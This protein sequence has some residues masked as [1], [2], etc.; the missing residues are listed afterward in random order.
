MPTVSG[1]GATSGQATAAA[2]SSLSRD[3]VA[4][5]TGLPGVAFQEGGVYFDSA[6]NI[7]TPTADTLYVTLVSS[8]TGVRRQAS[9]A[10]LATLLGI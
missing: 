3:S 7:V 5:V 1:A 2:R 4:I 10:E 6:F 8:R 9:L